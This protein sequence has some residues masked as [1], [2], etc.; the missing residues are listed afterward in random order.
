[1]KGLIS[2]SSP[3]VEGTVGSGGL[4]PRFSL[5][6]HWLKGCYKRFF[7]LVGLDPVLRIRM[8]DPV[9][10]CPLDPGSYFRKL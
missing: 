8:R 6:K 5:H 9:P 10:F 7:N 4:P 2:F 3:M 1:M